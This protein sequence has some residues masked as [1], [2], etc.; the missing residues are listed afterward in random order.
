MFHD[1][2]RLEAT[3]VLSSFLSGVMSPGFGP[4]YHMICLRKHTV[5]CAPLILFLQDLSITRACKRWQRLGG[6]RSVPWG[7]SWLCFAE[8]L[9]IGPLK[10]LSSGWPAVIKSSPNGCND[11]AVGS[12][13]RC[14]ILQLVRVFSL[15]LSTALH[16]N[17]QRSCDSLRSILEWYAF[18]KGSVS[19][20]LKSVACILKLCDVQSLSWVK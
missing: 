5:F 6:I 1:K 19:S 18:E 12:L 20:F 13:H 9:W 7:S 14:L 10:R 17:K 11:A 8:M 2:N 16:L 4:L 15:L 3:S